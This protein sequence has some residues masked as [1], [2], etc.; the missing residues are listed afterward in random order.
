MK[1]I[2]GIL[3]KKET[4]NR[5]VRPDRHS[6]TTVRQESD[7]RPRRPPPSGYTI[8]FPVAERLKIVELTISAAFGRDNIVQTLIAVTCDADRKL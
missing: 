1:E 7:G 3:R 4:L 8:L 5:P 6:E 2:D